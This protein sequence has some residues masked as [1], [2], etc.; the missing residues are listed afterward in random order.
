MEL[1]E[2]VTL[3]EEQ[4]EEIKM[5]VAERHSGIP[6]NHS[7]QLLELRKDVSLLIEKVA[8]LEER[9]KAL[10]ERVE[11]L[12]RRVESLETAVEALDKRIGMLEKKVD[13]LDSRVRRVE[14]VQ[15]VT[16][17]LLAP[18]ALIFYLRMLTS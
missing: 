17:A 5:L 6:N 11:A 15:W 12:E 14:L 9:V 7:G 1:I 18:Q 3:L 16:L 13:K 2:R 10:A 8:F 4:F